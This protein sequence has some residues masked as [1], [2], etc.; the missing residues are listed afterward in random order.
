M[1][2]NVYN[3]S[4]SPNPESKQSKNSLKTNTTL[5]SYFKGLVMKTLIITILLAIT[6]I[7]IN[8]I[9]KVE[10]I[11]EKDRIYLEKIMDKFHVKHKE[12]I[13]N[14][15]QFY[16][17]LYD[18]PVKI[19]GRMAATESGFRYYAISKWYKARGLF[20][21]R[22]S[23]DHVL[24][25]IDNGKL[26]KKLSEMENPNHAKYWLRIGYNIEGAMYILRY[27]KKKYGT[28]PLSLTAYNHGE[29]SDIIKAC[30][31]GELKPENV[32]YVRKILR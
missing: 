1:T 8:D 10:S 13:R 11:V 9:P 29:Y 23:W 20:Q 27:L 2:K 30:V 22:N 28:Y 14:R 25:I 3:I 31:A 12:R 19:V 21:V 6:C 18:H 26:G 7:A 5:L 32:R 16:A 15:I 4:S 17:Y 24:Y